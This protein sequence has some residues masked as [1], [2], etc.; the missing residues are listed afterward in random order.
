MNGL[1]PWEYKGNSLITLCE[2]CHKYEHAIGPAAT[3]AL[4]RAILSQDGVLNS[5]IVYLAEAINNMSDE[6][7]KQLC[8]V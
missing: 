6:Q 1:M 4:T 5:T 2:K 3:G 8:G 7:F